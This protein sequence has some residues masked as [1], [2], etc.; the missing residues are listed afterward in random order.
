MGMRKTAGKLLALGLILCLLLGM[1]AAAAEGLHREVRND[2][3]E[4]ETDIGYDGKITYGKVIPVRVTIRNRG[5]DLNA[6]AAV[7]AY[8]SPVKYDRFET[9]VFVPAG[10]ERTV[11]LPVRAE[12]R[13][14]TF[15]VE[16][17]ENG[18]VICAVN[19]KPAGTINPSS[20]MVA[21]LSTRPKNLAN[22]DISQ[23]N[24]TLQR[25]EYWQTVALTPE[26][27]PEDPEL[28]DAFGMAVLDDMDPALW[29]EKQRDTLLEW[30]KKGHVL[31]C[32]GG[33][34]APRNL[35][36]LGDMTALRC[37][38]FTVSDS[39][40]A[41]LESYAGRRATDRAPEVALARLSGEEPLVSDGN[42]NGLLWRT[43][44]GSGRIYTLAWEAGDPA[45]NGESL[46]HL[47]FQQMLIT[48]DPTLYSSILNSQDN[49][50]SVTAPGEFS[51]I[52]VRNTLPA[53]AWILAGAAAVGCVLWIVLKK[54]G[55]SKWMW[56]AIPALALLSA[57]AAAVVAGSSPLNRTVASVSVNT[58]Q[59]A[60]GSAVNC[61][62]VTAASPRAGLH[63]YRMDGED[64]R[65]VLYDGT[66]YWGEEE[67]EAPKEPVILR[68]IRRRG[69][70]N[71]TALNAQTPWETVTFSSI[72]EGTEGG[73]AKA[74]IWMESDG[75][76]GTVTNGTPYALKEGA[77]LCGYG[78]ALIP[79]LAP[80]ESANFALVAED[81]ADPNNPVFTDG[82]MIRNT[83]AGMYQVISQRWFG[84]NSE[85]YTDPKS[86][87]NNMTNG[88]VSQLT[89]ERVRA[90]GTDRETVNFFYSAQPEQ[91]EDIALYADG[92]KVDGVSVYRLLNVEMNY[93]TVGR[94]GVVFR[95][96]GMDPAVR[97]AITEDGLPAGSF[98]QENGR[99][100]TAYFPLN[101][102]PTFR[103]A[104]EGL[105]GTEITRLMIGMDQWYLSELKCYVLNAERQKWV[106]VK[107][108]ESIPRPEQYVDRDG[109]LY[110]Q[111]RPAHGESYTDISMP[112]LTLEGRVKK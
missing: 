45:L 111:F 64:L 16:I 66:Y 98:N 82:K 57:G 31:I 52:P 13:Q 81:A 5:G 21:V 78:F 32:G 62:A 10:G 103:F 77:V 25:Y 79:D 53:A 92:E 4:V 23:E 27:L 105:E 88:T 38:D 46:M 11:V 100:A 99:P 83:G 28:M 97:C 63:R 87:F 49:G 102:M 68:Q 14:E 67:D 3:L 80:G 17:V 37:A 9:E 8:I 91:A 110:C 75:F 34:A 71:E 76:H 86:I 95:A 84:R 107:P 85:D 12:S 72:R 108:N 54:R 55:T 1:G 42:G 101:E 47:F 109:N 51:P 60:D 2:L 96:P 18:Q 70:G 69:D 15:T 22:L 40:H 58:V 36:F 65:A 6:V 20:M 74:E 29:T 56:A 44:A 112:T 26:T 48:A 43:A 59:R 104:P 7:N 39:V 50:V 89:Q 35:A 41:A 24:D 94:T 73:Q 30:V 61:T 19:T 33:T 90:G 93:L 106:E